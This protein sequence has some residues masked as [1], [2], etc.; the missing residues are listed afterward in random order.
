MSVIIHY[1]YFSVYV[2]VKFVILRW[3]PSICCEC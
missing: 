2:I 3:L 1:T